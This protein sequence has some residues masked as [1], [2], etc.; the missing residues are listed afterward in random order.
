M[1]LYVTELIV[2]E[3]GLGKHGDNIP[4]SMQ[5]ALLKYITCTFLH[6]CSACFVVFSPILNVIGSQP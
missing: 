4:T 6:M 3:G 5:A 2:G 1:A